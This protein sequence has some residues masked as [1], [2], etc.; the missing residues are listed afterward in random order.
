MS[1]RDRIYKGDL[2]T[3]INLNDV[4][5]TV[6]VVKHHGKFLYFQWQ[7]KN[8]QFKLCLWA[9]DSSSSVYDVA[10]SCGKVAQES[11]SPCS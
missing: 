9:G 7:G 10:H 1:L 5:L 8:Y 4:Y 6:S 11:K 2:M 3:N